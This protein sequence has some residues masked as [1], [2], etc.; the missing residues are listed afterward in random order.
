M[1]PGLKAGWTHKRRHF[2][3]FEANDLKYF[4]LDISK[5]DFSKIFFDWLLWV[6]TSW[7]AAVFSFEKNKS[8]IH[9]P[10]L[11][12][13]YFA[14]FVWWFF[15]MRNL[16]EINKINQRFCILTGRYR[17]FSS[18]MLFSNLGSLLCPVIIKATQSQQEWQYGF[19][20]SLKWAAS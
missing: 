8:G 19:N 17:I 3:L 1:N 13:N 16:L 6:T 5:L 12:L 11:E 14:S 4:Q 15:W 7:N 9:I 20:S 18:I 2:R 10:V